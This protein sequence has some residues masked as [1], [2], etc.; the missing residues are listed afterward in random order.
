LSKDRSSVGIHRFNF[1]RLSLV[2]AVL[3]AGV[4][5]RSDKTA[6]AD[7]ERRADAEIA[8]LRRG[9]KWDEQATGVKQ[10]P[11]AV[12][13]G[14]MPLVHLFDIGGAIR[15]MDLTSKSRLAALSVPDRTLVRVDSRNGVTVGPDNI[16]P[17][18]LPAEHTY[19]IFLDPTTPNTMRQGV[20]PARVFQP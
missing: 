9:A 20:G 7:A 10:E 2:T 17:G 12:A 15:V 3:I 8:E 18:P 11:V 13:E 4:G 6:Q 14:P 1:A 16:V 19:G 5:C